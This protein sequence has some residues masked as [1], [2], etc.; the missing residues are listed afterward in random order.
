MCQLIESMWIC[1]GFTV[2]WKPIAQMLL[3]VEEVGLK[4]ALHGCSTWASDHIVV[5]S[6]KHARKNHAGSR[7][8]EQ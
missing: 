5:L 1:V 8:L 7:A 3:Q 6:L 2:D 4:A